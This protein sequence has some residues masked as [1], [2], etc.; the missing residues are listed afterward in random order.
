MAAASTSDRWLVRL[1]AASVLL[2]AG[3]LVSFEG[4]YAADEVFVQEDNTPILSKPGVGGKILIRVDTGFVLT[5][6]GRDGEWLEVTSPVL[7]LPG[8]SLWIPA[9]RVGNDVPGSLEASPAAG[10]A[11]YRLEVTGSPE[12][13]I[14]ARCRVDEGRPDLRRDDAFRTFVDNLPVVIELAAPVDCFVRMFDPP[15]EMQVVLR[16]SD[17]VVVAAGT[18]FAGSDVVHV[19]TDGPWGS[20]GSFIGTTG[21]LTFNGQSMQGQPSGAVIPP[22]GNPVPPLGNAVPPLVSLVPVQ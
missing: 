9:G 4:V 1:A 3:M 21:F 5:V 7:K 19:R 15:G 2:L 12:V 17:G 16:R 13:R 22:L 14:R 6:L 18:A 11:V 8:D 20:A 10:G